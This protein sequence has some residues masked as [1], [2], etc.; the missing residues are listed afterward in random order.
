MLRNTSYNICATF[1]CYI[2]NPPELCANA[3]LGKTERL[4]LLK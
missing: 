3:P 1:L 2:F 4:F